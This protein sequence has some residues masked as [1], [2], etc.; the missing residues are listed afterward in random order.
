MY[1]IQAG[2]VAFLKGQSCL[3]EI[4]PHLATFRVIQFIDPARRALMKLGQESA[5]RLRA[6]LSIGRR[7]TDK[8]IVVGK[9]GPGFKLPSIA[10]RILQQATVQSANVFFV[11]KEMLFLIGPR[12]HGE[13]FPPHSSGALAHEANSDPAFPP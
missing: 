6:I 13:K 3:P 12:G 11:L 4:V 5:Q 8:V 2:E 9:N 7:M 1:V 10:F